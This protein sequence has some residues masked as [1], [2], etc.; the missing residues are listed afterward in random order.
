MKNLYNENYKIL[1][2]EIKGNINKWKHI[3]CSRIGRLTIVKMWI[4]SKMIYRL[5]VVTIKTPMNFF[6]PEI[7]KLIWKF[8]WNLKEPQIAKWTLKSKNVGLLTLPEFKTYYNLTIMKR[9]LHWHKE[10][11]THRK[12]K[13]SPEID[14]HKN[15]QVIFN[16]DTKTIQSRKENNFNK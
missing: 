12:K 8:I 1:L 2:K 16:K 13:K 14:Q 15:N 6:F 7:K 9:V 10:I 5:K 3:L 11:Q 4:L